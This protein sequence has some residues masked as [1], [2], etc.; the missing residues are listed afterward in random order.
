VEAV[1][2]KVAALDQPVLLAQGDGVQEEPLEDVAVGEALGLRLRD[3]LVRG[4]PLTQPVSYGYRGLTL[5]QKLYDS[6]A[7]THY[8]NTWLR[9]CGAN[10]AS[11][12]SSEAPLTS[13]RGG[14]APNEYEYIPAKVSTTCDAAREVGRESSPYQHTPR[15]TQSMRGRPSIRIRPTCLCG[16]VVVGE[17]K[18]GIE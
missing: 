16:G 17:L 9:G 6:R 1:D 13:D 12:S 8:G 3:R 5:T 2:G 7:V 11:V 15:P 4:Q 18:K 14:A 10:R